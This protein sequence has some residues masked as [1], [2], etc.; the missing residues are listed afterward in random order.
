MEKTITITG[1]KGV[2]GQV[3]EVRALIAS[4]K[5]MEGMVEDAK[6]VILEKT[7]AGKDYLH[8]SFSPYSKAYA[9]KKG[10]TRVDLKVSGTMLGAIKTAVLSPN[11]GRVFVDSVSEPGGKINADMLAQIHNTGTGTKRR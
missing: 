6:K 10:S 8:R 3:A 4:P 5:P 11:H 9:K 7:A 2:L 1:L